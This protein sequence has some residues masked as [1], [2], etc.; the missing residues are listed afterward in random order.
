MRFLSLACVYPRGSE[1][2]LFTELPRRGIL[3]NSVSES[4]GLIRYWVTA[5]RLCSQTVP[6]VRSAVLPPYRTRHRPFSTRCLPPQSA[7]SQQRPELSPRG[8]ADTTDFLIPS[9]FPWWLV[10]THLIGEGGADS[11]DRGLKSGRM[12]RLALRHER[13]RR[14][15]GVALFTENPRSGLLGNSETQRR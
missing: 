12:F 8:Q 9:L 7:R 10:Q 6:C 15:G 14:G 5:S 13:Q 1:S 3:G 4:S 2:P 11:L